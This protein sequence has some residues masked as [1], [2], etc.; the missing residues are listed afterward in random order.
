M[1]P[2]GLIDSIMKDDTGFAGKDMTYIIESHHAPGFQWKQEAECLT[3]TIRV[4]QIDTISVGCMFSEIVL[5]VSL[6]VI[7]GVILSKFGLAVLFGWFL[8]W[9]LGNFKEENSY[10][11]RMKR[12]QQI[13]NWAQ[14]MDDHGP[15]APPPPPP[16]SD[17]LKRRSLFPT[18]S[19]FTPLLHGSTRFDSEKPMM[20]AWKT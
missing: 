2:G 20:P 8:S 12:E 14:N 16:Q 4:G 18:S 9:R 1:T 3:Q 11:A 10:A 6:I 19:R 15:V 5:Y 13:E 17:K 7:L